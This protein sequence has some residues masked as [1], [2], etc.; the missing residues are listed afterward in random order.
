MKKQHERTSCQSAALRIK[1]KY[2]KEEP[3]NVDAKVPGSLVI[4]AES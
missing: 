4:S 3:R 1:R 2:D